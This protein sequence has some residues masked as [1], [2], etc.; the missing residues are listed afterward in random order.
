MESL[1]GSLPSLLTHRCIW[2]QAPHNGMADLTRYGDRWYCALREG[3]HHFK[4]PS[5]TLQILSS[6]D[7]EKWEAVAWLQGEGYDLRD[8]HFSMLPDERLMLVMGGT[9]YDEERNQMRLSTRVSF[10]EGGSE[11][12]APQQILPDEEW[13]WRVTW[14]E[15][16]AYGCA[17]LFSEPGN[18]HS[19]WVLK[20][21][22]SK[23]ALDWE[24]IKRFSIPGRPNETTLR[25]TEEGEMLALVRREGEDCGYWLG[26]SSSPYRSWK[27]QK[28]TVGLGGP[29]FLLLPDGRMWAAA[30]VSSDGRDNTEGVTALGLLTAHS[31]Q[32]LLE[33]P[34][35]GDNS[36][37]GMVYHDGKLWVVYYSS[38][39]GKAKIYLA[40]IALP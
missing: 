11:W 24:E 39:E 28:T 10:S 3:A 30:R 25:F 29:N 13:L 6:E 21:Y 12:S 15:G 4:G 31:F 8:P 26:S 32:P 2:E 20:L 17:Y 33:L 14:Y 38:H 40:T 18:F 1:A 23:N 35:G 27:W 22:C 16:I 19:E 5:G 37:P 7:G 36:Y 9:V 34:S